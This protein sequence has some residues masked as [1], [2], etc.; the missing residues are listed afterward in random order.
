MSL[1]LPKY[2][3]VKYKQA[4]LTLNVDCIILQG[5]FGSDRQEPKERQCRACVRASVYF[6]QLSTQNG[7]KKVSAAF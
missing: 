6:M 2:S 7:S 5:L 1:V 4:S 3:Q